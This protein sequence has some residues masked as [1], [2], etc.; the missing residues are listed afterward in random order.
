MKTQLIYL[1]VED[2]DSKIELHD[3]AIFEMFL[4][5]FFWGDKSPNFPVCIRPEIASNRKY[6]YYNFRV[7]EEPKDL[8]EPDKEL[9]HIVVSSYRVSL[10]VIFE[11]N[12]TN[13]DDWKK[14][15]DVVQE[16]IF[17]AEQM[18]FRITALPKKPLLQSTDKPWEVVEDHLSDRIIVKLWHGGYRNSEIG[19]KVNLAP[20]TVT[21]V[22]STLRKRYGTDV[23][24]TNDQ[25]RKKP[26]T[27]DN[28]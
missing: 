26:K 9:A 5:Q 24:P 17:K 15:E 11:G 22:L 4:I 16:V 3:P 28:L 1:K 14:V 10:L 27:D 25:R 7:L 2:R 12:E 8:D 13:I 21:N 6:P 20:E 19:K 18:G 23:V